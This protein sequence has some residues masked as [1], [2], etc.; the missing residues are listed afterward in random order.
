MRAALAL[1]IAACPTI[2][3]HISVCY[4]IVLVSFLRV[5]VTYLLAF[6]LPLPLQLLLL[7]LLLLSGATTFLDRSSRAERKGYV[8]PSVS[9]SRCGDSSIHCLKDSLLPPRPMPQ[10]NP[11]PMP[12]QPRLCLAF[13]RRL[14]HPPP[15]PV[16]SRSGSSAC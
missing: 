11:Q 2:T 13:P 9:G 7:L 8:T 14:H 1:Q 3:R 5:T 6:S 16:L 15:L 10:P 4:F 12:P